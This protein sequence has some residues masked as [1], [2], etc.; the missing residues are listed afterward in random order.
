MFNSQLLTDSK[1][2][3]FFAENKIQD[4][5]FLPNKILI[6]FHSAPFLQKRSFLAKY[7]G[8]KTNSEK[9]EVKISENI[10]FYKSGPTTY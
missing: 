6:E 1:V 10:Y 8:P 3:G 4:V 7:L 9:D 5:E 2:L